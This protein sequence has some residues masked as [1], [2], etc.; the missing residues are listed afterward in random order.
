MKVVKPNRLGILT[1]AMTGDGRNYRLAVAALVGVPFGAPKAMRMES[2]IWKDVGDHVPGGMVDEGNAKPRG[3]VLV[4]GSAMAPRGELAQAVMTRLV[5]KR[6][7]ATLVDKRVA[8]WGDR[9]W[10]GSSPTEA[11]GFS[12][13]P[14]DWAHAFGGEGYEANPEGL[15][16]VALETAHGPVVPLPNVEDPDELITS[17]KDRRRPAGYGALPL[18]WPQR[19][20]FA[21]TTYDEAWLRTRFP[22]PA[23]DFDPSFHQLAYPDQQLDGELFDGTESFRIEGMHADGA[24]ELS[25]A[26][27]VVKAL[28]TLRDPAT[29]EET[30]TSIGL[31]LETVHLLPNVERAIL[32]FR[33]VLPIADEDADDVVHL[34]L[35]AED[36][37]HPKPIEHYQRVLAGRLDKE[38]GALLSMK[39]EDLMPAEAEG[40]LCKPDYG[41]MTDKTRLD[42]RALKKGEAGRKK[43]LAEAKQ[44]LIDAG[45]EVPE[46]FDGPPAP[47]IPDPYDVDALLE[48]SEEMDAKAAELEAQAQADKERLEKEARASF[49]EAGFDYDAETA[50]AMDGAGGPPDF[51]ADD[52]LVMLHDMARIAAEGGMPM[53]DLERDLL[54]PKYERTLRDLEDRVQESYVRFAHLMPIAAMPEEDRRQQLR[55]MVVAAKDADEPLEGRNLVGA[56]LHGLDLSGMRLS[57]AFLE[58]ADLRGANL[59]G[60]DLRGAVLARADLTDTDLSACDLTGANL[61]ET[62]LVRTDLSD[63]ILDDTVLM[64]SVLDGARLHGARLSNTDFLEVTFTEADF[65]HAETTQALFLQTDLRGVGFVGA[66]LVEARFLQVDLRGVDFTG[67][68]LDKAQLLQ[69]Q[70][71]GA[72]FTGASMVGAG[73]VHESSFLECSFSGA[74]LT[75]ANLHDSPLN[76]SDLSGAT[77]DGANLI[78][79]DLRGANLH[80][81]TAREALMMRTRLEGADMRGADLL[82]V[83]AQRADLRG[84]DL[85]G[86]NLS[87]GDVSLAFFD[88]DTKVDEALLIDTR[89]D[90]KRAEETTR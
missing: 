81:I 43:K 84:A 24:R 39:D 73:L 31:R 46:D 21:G 10:K 47:R 66:R 82:G 2:A 4:H 36:P 67:A 59:H 71:D 85:T 49:E 77:L 3:E 29:D 40:W 90:P 19:F 72:I 53:E 11:V 20:R 51:S 87:R 50:K 55:V 15:G 89:V 30:F 57:G 54:D 62:K 42:H 23:I 79:T 6:G 52:H 60:C 33:G 25:L 13:M 78:K 7:D 9:F 80:R 76:G 64:K 22:G 16:A 48:L 44:A 88:G 1:R 56:D 14:L 65:S 61:G 83:I 68:V 28:A 26:P 12:E 70:A 17:P 45:F 38:K 75:R 74:D 86:S 37:A 27:L 32:V 63:A 41:D 58:R 34:M 69:C 8:V 35:A 18:A 5:A